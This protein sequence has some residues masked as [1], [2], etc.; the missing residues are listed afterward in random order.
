MAYQEKSDICL[1]KKSY[2]KIDILE[3][4]SINAP[5]R[6]Y[7]KAVSPVTQG[8]HLVDRVEISKFDV[9]RWVLY[10]FNPWRCE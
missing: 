9:F 4:H 7:L 8:Q 3:L 10:L 5:N 2:K 6:V 1:L